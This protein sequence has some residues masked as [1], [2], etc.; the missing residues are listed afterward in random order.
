MS[1]AFYD[2]TLASLEASAESDAPEWL[3]R[4][5]AA[6]AERFRA[7]GFP[8]TKDEAW[9]F[10]S[11]RPLTRIAF[12]P[13][14]GGVDVRCADERVRIEPLST[15][16]ADVEAVLGQLA[17]NE[18]FAALNTALF[19]DATI[20]RI[21]KG[22]VVEAPIELGFASPSG[23]PTV[24]YPRIVVIAEPGSEATLVETHAPRG[25]HLTNAVVE[26]SVG[27]NASV[28]HLRIHEGHEQAFTVQTIAVHQAR[29][30]RYRSRVF[31]FGGALSRLDIVSVLDGAGAD[32]LL[33]GLYLV[34]GNAHVDHR[35]LVRHAR[36]HG[37]SHEKYKGILDDR[38]HAV[39]DGTIVVDRDAQKTEAHQENR[40]LLLSSDAVVNTKPHLEIDA[41]DV[42][43][44]HGATV[45][46]LD[47][48][49]LF[50]LRARGID[51]AAARTLLTHAFAREMV[52]RVGLEPARDRLTRLVLGHLPRGELLED[53]E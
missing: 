34:R 3:C 4:L 50:Y 8:T 22:A 16:G 10:T 1:T 20:L 38:A 36:P 46:R 28:E 52:E 15:A 41:D 48:Q 39:F 45:G 31:S 35:T 11:V 53:A 49:Q 14:G 17:P 37:S 2:S 6:G 9:R 19:S 26:I 40:N 43:C 5:R 13:R 23:D 42:K 30:A 18:F 51:E 47:D 12:T 32:C 7:H 29:D 21:P 33:D 44:S 25:A 27:E 24:A